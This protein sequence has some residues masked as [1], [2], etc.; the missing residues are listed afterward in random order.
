MDLARYIDHTNLKP[1]AKPADIIRLC[2]EAAQYQFAA[3]C[4]NPI[5]VDLAVHHL[6]GTG[7]KVATVIGF[8][9]GA[10]PTTVKVYEARQAIADKADELDMVIQLGAAKIGLWEAV[11]RD[12]HNVVTAAEEK[13]VKVIIETALLTEE[14]KKQAC[15]AVLA[16]GA[17]FVKTSTGFGP[18]GATVQDVQLLKQVTQGRIGIKAAGGIRTRA[19][20]EALIAAGATRLGTSAG[21]NLIK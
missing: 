11:I 5:Y 21:V 4:V 6:K 3:V 16:G 18:G 20:A 8:P 13:T 19:D 17:H 15:R 1:E 7:V 10:V 14:E 12:I 2:Q 9:L